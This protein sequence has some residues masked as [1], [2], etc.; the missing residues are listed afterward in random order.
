MAPRGLKR[1]LLSFWPHEALR[2]AV[3]DAPS[4]ASSTR[5]VSFVCLH[6]IRELH[7]VEQCHEF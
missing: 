4:A 2:L 6:A 1:R 7:S 5:P 3:R